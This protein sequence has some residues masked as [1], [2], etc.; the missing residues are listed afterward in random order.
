MTHAKRR[1]TKSD[2]SRA[3]SSNRIFSMTPLATAVVAAIGSTGTAMAQ[4]E[5]NSAV[6]L[7]EIIVTGTKREMNVQDVP[8]SIDVLSGV[9]LSKMGA[10]DLQDTLRALPSVNLTALQP[11]QNSLTIRGISSGAYNY[12]TEAQAAVYLDEQ[13]M[14][15]ARNRLESGMPTL[16]AL[17]CC[18]VRKA[19]CS[20]RVPRPAP[21]VTSP[22]SRR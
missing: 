22:T 13:P 1:K 21:C 16:H 10:K 11:G 15:S 9:E 7:D 18:R 4:Q 19:L 5:D 8:Q 12:Y 20:A 2:H 14:T 17:R 6:V 3:Q